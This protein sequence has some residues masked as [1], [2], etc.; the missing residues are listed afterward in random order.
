M[1]PVERK[2]A[3]KR[4]QEFKLNFRKLRKDILR[5]LKIH[6]NPHNTDQHEEYAKKLRQ[7]EDVLKARKGKKNKEKQGDQNQDGS[8]EDVNTT[9]NSLSG[10]VGEGGDN[11]PEDVR[12]VQ[13]LLKEKGYDIAVDGSMGPQ[14]MRTIREFQ[15]NAFRSADGLIEPNKRSWRQLNEAGGES[16]SQGETSTGGEGSNSEP[17]NKP[18]WISIAEGEL[19]VKEIRGKSHNPRVI[20]YHST[21][22]GFKDDETPWCASFVTWVMKKAGVDGGFGTAWAQGWN[23]Y[24]KAADGPAYGAVGVIKHTAKTGHVGF[25]IGK[26]GDNIILLGGNQGNMVKKSSYPISK[27]IGFRFPSGYDIPADAYNFGA[28][29]GDFSGTDSTR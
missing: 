21:T 28:I 22:G 3:R 6:E 29:E 18:N 12:I 17:G 26:Q 27:F 10:S 11:K 1:K 20:E 13:E 16:T 24:G 23:N 8:Q 5:F 14:T 7:V 2:A 25:V 15:M 4:N 19:G 9:P